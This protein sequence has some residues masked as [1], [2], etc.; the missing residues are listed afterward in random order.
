MGKVQVTQFLY[1]FKIK[2][3]QNTEAS[4]KNFYLDEMLAAKRANIAA[5]ECPQTFLGW[6]LTQTN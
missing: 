2:L 6:S 5:G 1:I 4:L 3:S